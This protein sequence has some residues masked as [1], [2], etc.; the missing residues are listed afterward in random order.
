MLQ[1]VEEEEAKRMCTELAP[2]Y[3]ILARVYQL[4]A[5]ADPE[6]EPFELF[7]DGFLQFCLVRSLKIR[8]TKQGITSVERSS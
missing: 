4:Y 3:G 2:V 1:V 6:E 7:W 8:C 5:A